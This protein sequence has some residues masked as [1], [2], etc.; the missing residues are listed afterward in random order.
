MLCCSRARANYSANQ[1]RMETRC[2]FALGPTRHALQTHYVAQGTLAAK[3]PPKRL[4]HVKAHPQWAHLDSNQGLPGYEPGALTAELW[5]RT[6]AGDGIRTRDNLLG[7]QA[8][9][10]LSYTRARRRRL[11]AAV[12]AR[13]LEPP[14]P[15]SQT[16][17]A[18]NCATPRRRI[19]YPIG[20]AWSI[21]SG[22]ECG[23]TPAEC[24]PERSE[25]S[26]SRRAETLRYAQSLP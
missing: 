15:A 21:C 24:H 22:R 2:C 12:G 8:L 11:P 5:A 19:V 10:Q 4:A 26:R 6:G 17:C 23:T 3:K 1:A 25:G 14:T 20:R 7:R 13:G 18:T 9:Y 16:L